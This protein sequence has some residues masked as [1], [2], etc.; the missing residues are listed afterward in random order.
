GRIWRR[1]RGT[2]QSPSRVALSVAIGLFIGC[3]P[4]YGAHFLLCSLICLPFGLDLLLCYLVANISNP[5][6]APF[7]I[8]LE[9]ELGSLVTT[10][11]H[12][13]FTLARARQTGFL[14]F[15]WQAGVGSVFV[16]SGLAVLGAAVAYA[17]ASKTEHRASADSDGEASD[18]ETKLEAA[19]LRTIERYRAAP[20]GDRMY[21]AAKLRSDPLTR[22]LATLPFD[23]GSVLD[24]GAGRGQFGLFLV[25][26]GRCRE[27]S[28][29]DGDERKVKVAQLAAS[30]SVHFEQRDLLALPE[31]EVDT[32]LLIDVL[33]YLPLLEQDD[34]LRACARVARAQI[35]IRELDAVAGARNFVTRAGEWLTKLTGYNRGRAARHYRPASAIT[36]QLER[37]GF[38]CNVQSASKGTPFGNVL[39]VATCRN[40][41]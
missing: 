4:V 5:L 6:V 33:H 10:G 36:E 13:A 1:L 15:I 34:L 26:L 23:L 28:G 40:G 24:A 20:V 37:L 9:V 41:P 35:V 17:V 19:T 31:A 12:A 3:L 30:D 14:G 22:L 25:E 11:K 27:L 39:I 29:F 8:T 38:S 21:V 2:R 18:E 32:V 7:L 16:G